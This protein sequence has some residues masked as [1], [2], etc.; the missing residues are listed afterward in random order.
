MLRKLFCVLVFALA[1]CLLASA[2][3]DIKMVHFVPAD[4]TSTLAEREKIR[5]LTLET[6]ELYAKELQ[7][8][9][10]GLKTFKLD[11]QVYV[12]KG[13]KT[14]KDYTH[15]D[16]LD[17]DLQ[18]FIDRH[19]DKHGYLVFV[20][21]NEIP[22]WNCGV[23]YSW[24]NGQGRGTIYG[25]RSYMST[26]QNCLTTQLVAHEAGH[27][28]AL[29]HDLNSNPL[30]IMTLG[31]KFN[32]GQAAWLS[33]SHYF[34]ENRKF[35]Q[36][37]RL[38][39][40]HGL[41]NKDGD[42]IITLSV[43]DDTGLFYAQIWYSNNSFF[44][45]LKGLNDIIMFKASQHSIVDNKLHVHLMDSDGNRT[46]YKV[47]TPVDEREELEVEEEIEVVKKPASVRVRKLA[48]SWASLKT[49]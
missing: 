36:A 49:K 33:V 22:G 6:Q 25:G 37:P 3:Y 38:K 12:V 30:T 18:S 8:H 40:Q 9:G 32:K 4:D 15:T 5:N 20:D 44:F 11:Q 39:H 16:L 7:R 45:E 13:T 1:S 48:T 23:A 27:V 26:S 31:H 29:S 42:Y 47:P 19:G 34:Q 41:I 43:E 35:G 2:D 28:F 21:K 14:S 46:W 24:E 10:F 17:K